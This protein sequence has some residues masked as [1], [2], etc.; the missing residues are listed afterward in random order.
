M[1]GLKESIFRAIEW[2][3]DAVR[4]GYQA[5]K[6][7]KPAIEHPAIVDDPVADFRG[8]WTMPAERISRH[9]AVFGGF[10]F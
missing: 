9:A 10:V 4:P 2:R 6:F 1:D 8:G 3:A 7:I 5:G